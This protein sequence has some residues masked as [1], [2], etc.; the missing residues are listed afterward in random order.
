[1]RVG[2]CL[3]RVTVSPRKWDR[4]FLKMCWGIEREYNDET[5]IPDKRPVEHYTIDMIHVADTEVH[6][7]P[8]KQQSKL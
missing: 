8:H 2:S 6:E 7:H 5:R 4:W 1:M 3:A